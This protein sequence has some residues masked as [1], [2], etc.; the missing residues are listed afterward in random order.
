[1]HKMDCNIKNI[2]N[3]IPLVFDL[4]GTLIANDS[5]LEGI[6]LA[7]KK[8]PILVF[9]LPFWIICGKLYF[10]K[11][12]H[13]YI[14]IK[15]EHFVF[16]DDVLDFAKKEKEKGRDIILASATLK[17]NADLFAAHLGLF[18]QTFGSSENLNLRSDNKRKLLI[19][20]FGEFSFD[21]AGDSKA[22]IKVWK[23]ARKSILVYPNIFVNAAARKINNIEKI[24]PVNY[25]K[26]LVYFL[27]LAVND[28]GL[29]SIFSLIILNLFKP[30]NILQ[31]ISLEIISAMLVFYDILSLFVNKDNFC[32]SLSNIIY[33]FSG[34]Y[35]LKVSLFSI[36]ILNVLSLVIL[37]ISTILII[38]TVNIML[39]VNIIYYEKTLIRSILDLLIITFLMLLTK[40]S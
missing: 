20:K 7:V 29:L 30:I 40:I 3:K 17:E 39:I 35:L 34:N 14:E 18:S 24:F 31:F 38:L 11:K 16:R 19:D 10:K 37:P 6:I 27:N 28:L 1:M 5:V 32:K 15:P 25:K 13:K 8:T 33:T 26:I 23:S 21:Y 9:F 22:D 4:D 36:L 2:E 12:I